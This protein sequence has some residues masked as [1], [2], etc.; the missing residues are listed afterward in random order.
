MAVFWNLISTPL[1]FAIPEELDKGNTAI[2]LAGLF[3]AVG[4]GL[5]VWAAKATRR[6]LA[7]GATPLTLDPYPGSIGGQ[8]AGS[9]ETNLR[10]TQQPKLS[11]D[12][13]LPVQLYVGLG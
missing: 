11:S 4:L 2:L 1:L 8:V 5:L 13:E 10:Y 7:V 9:I 12:P 6:W 3:P